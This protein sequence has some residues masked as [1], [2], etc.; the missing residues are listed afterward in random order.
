MDTPIVD[1]TTGKVRGI[2]QDGIQVFKGIPYGAPTGGER[3]FG[4]PA[5]P[6]PWSGV[7]DAFAYGHSAPQA[8]SG[9]SDAIVGPSFPYGEDCLV[10]NVWTPGV[11]DGR[12]RPVMVR[13]HGGGFLNLTGSGPYLEG[14][15]L[16]RRSDVVVVTLNHRLGVFGY[17]YLGAVARADD[18]VVANAGMLDLVAA[19]QWVRDN[20]AAFGGDP[21]NVT[22]FGESGGGGKVLTLLGMPDAAGLFHRAIAESSAFRVAMPET[23]AETAGALM[24]HLGVATVAQLRAVLTDQLVA[25]QAAQLERGAI[26][27]GPVLDPAT[28]P[29]NPFGPVAVP[30]AAAIPLLI[31][32]N[33]DEVTEFLLDMPNYGTMTD[34]EAEAM[35]AGDGPFAL[36]K[37]GAGLY[38]AYRRL[39]PEASPTDVGVAVLSDHFRINAIRIA[40]S[41]AAAGQAPAYMYLLTWKSP[42]EDGKLKA[43]HG[44][45]VPLVMHNIETS[46]MRRWV[47]GPHPTPEHVAD[48][49]RLS[50]VISD[51]WVAFARTGSPDHAGLPAWPPYRP[52]TRAT[53]VF[54]SVCRV[55]HDPLRAERQAWAGIS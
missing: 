46:S 11:G 5:P 41:Y 22:I 25:A 34:A 1:T 8:W 4:P 9:G 35:V 31:G 15:A 42:A 10:L 39:H 7:R 24:A 27:V 52:D 44:L 40:E 28:L 2:V 13:I 33:R 26:H 3:R 19:L 48:V 43:C 55:E 47:M 20:I 51:A 32:S 50:D 16:S 23:A 30:M 36:S 49:Y 29:V 14:L 45:E 54:D 21:G 37:R 53:M 12:R 6:E 18:G 17:L 38:Q